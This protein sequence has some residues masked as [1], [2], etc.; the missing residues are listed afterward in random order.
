M[1]TKIEVFNKSQLK[2]GMPD[3]RPGDTIKVFQKKHIEQLLRNSTGSLF[4]FKNSKV[5]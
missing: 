5:S 3:I 1:T 2:N 4:Y